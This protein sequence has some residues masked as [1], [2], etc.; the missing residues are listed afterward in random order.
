MARVSV[1]P[2]DLD[3]LDGRELRQ[4]VDDLR[5]A[6]SRGGRPK[7]EGRD[8]VLDVDVDVEVLGDAVVAPSL[9]LLLGRTGEQLVE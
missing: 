7:L 1:L 5:G 2:L 6:A 8:T 4:G 9:R 3:R